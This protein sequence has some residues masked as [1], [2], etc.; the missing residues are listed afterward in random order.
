MPPLMQRLVN[1]CGHHVSASEMLKQHTNTLTH[2]HMHT[3]TTCTS[4][5]VEM[6][7]RA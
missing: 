2:T 7:P 4:G 1:V 5:G 6:C 3:H